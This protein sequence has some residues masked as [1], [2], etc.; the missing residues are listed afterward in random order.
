MKLSE[1][2]QIITW[3]MSEQSPKGRGKREKRKT[4]GLRVGSLG[5]VLVIHI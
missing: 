3:A 1:T 2:V 4:E 5:I